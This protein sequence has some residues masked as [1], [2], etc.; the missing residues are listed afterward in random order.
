VELAP[1]VSIAI[2]TYNHAQYLPICIDGA[3]FQDYS[4][5][6][7]VVVNACSPDNTK[8]VL[9]EYQQTVDQEQVSFASVY[10]E[11]TGKVERGYYDRY[12]KQGRT[13]KVIHLDEDPG[14]SETY[15]IAVRESTGEFVTTI[16][17]DD[18]AHPNLVSR[19]L[20]ELLRGADFAYGDILI[21]DDAGRVIRKF[22]FPDYDPKRVLAD[23]YLMGSAKLWRKNLH[24]RAGW[25]SHDY[26]LTQDYEMFFRF[27]EIG[28]KFVHVPE[29]LYSARWHGPERKDGNHA[30]NRESKIHTESIKVALRARQWLA[31]KTE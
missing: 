16:V 25:F 28:A 13:L 15:N 24:D 8:Q 5:I 12:P 6:E 26:P 19:L 1:L 30:P 21:V 29:V 20:P 7:I 14:L 10:N 4:N 31:S 3:W 9:E 27:A 23:W 18:I 22:A 2:P 11:E 17:S